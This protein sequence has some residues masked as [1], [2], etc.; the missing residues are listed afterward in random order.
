[1]DSPSH[2]SISISIYLCLSM[3][4][5]LWSGTSRRP[6]YAWWS[7]ER[8]EVRRTVQ[9]GERNTCWCSVQC[10]SAAEEMASSTKRNGFRKESFILSVDV[11]TTTLRCNVFDQ[12]AKIRGTCSG[13]VTLNP[14]FFPCCL[15]TSYP[16]QDKPINSFV[17]ARL[18]CCIQNQAWWSWIQRNCLMGL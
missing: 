3:S 5:F 10:S 2:S 16:P 11:G 14:F 9:G 7:D 13:K 1:M 18:S 8:S 6:A 15:S 4:V 17:F 12:E